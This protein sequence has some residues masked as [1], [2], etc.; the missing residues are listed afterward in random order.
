[1]NASTFRNRAVTVISFDLDDTLWDVDEVM[2]EATRVQHEWLA[3]HRPKVVE[4]FS[5][6]DLFAFK[7]SLIKQRPILR[8]RI[9]EL[10]LCALREAQIAA[11]YSAD[12][13]ESGAR[14]AFE[15]VLEAR[16]QVTYFEHALEVLAAL[17]EN[18]TLVALSNGNADISRLEIGRFFHSAVRAE[19]FDTSK[20][21]PV[22]FR[23]ALTPTGAS[24]EQ[25]VHVGDHPEH[26]VRG[27]HDSGLHSVW[28]NPD[29][30]PWPG[31]PAPSEE[32]S[33]LDQLP[34]AISAI[35]RGL[36]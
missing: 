6:R 27:A 26:D 16:H 25:C 22:L 9:S 13:A 29:A 12:Q 20:P 34:A 28:F 32:I 5:P 19:Q 4:E 21:D 31:G 30:R 36:H 14:E 11:G 3:V 35:E 24:P 8:H 2:T 1:M 15:V 33:K 18:Y 7:Q 10:R 23:A 17:A